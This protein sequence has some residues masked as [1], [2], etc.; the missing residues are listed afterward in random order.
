MP[1][2]SDTLHV[3]GKEKRDNTLH[4]MLHKTKCFCDISV[5]KYQELH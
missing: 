3:S 2:I 4:K 5:T 1:A